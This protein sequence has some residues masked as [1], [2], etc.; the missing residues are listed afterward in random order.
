MRSQ[1]HS[2]SARRSAL[3]FL[4][5]AALGATF[6]HG[7]QEAPAKRKRRD[8]TE[9]DRVLLALYDTHL[10]EAGITWSTVVYRP[11][12]FADGLAIAD[13]T[14]GTLKVDGA[15]AYGGWDFF[16]AYNWWVI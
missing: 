13:P 11:A 10:P 7:T 3:K 8:G 16:S 12:Q 4:V 1:R 2:V 6:G 5:G 9:G 15:N 14:R